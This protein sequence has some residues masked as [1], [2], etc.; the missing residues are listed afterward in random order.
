[1]RDLLG[2]EMKE[3]GVGEEPLEPGDEG[4]ARRGRLEGMKKWM[5]SLLS[6]G[7]RA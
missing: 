5:R 1:M 6:L 4:G 3:E 7:M 2:L